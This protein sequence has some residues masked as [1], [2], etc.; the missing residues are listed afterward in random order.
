MNNL[1][2]AMVRRDLQKAIQLY[3]DLLKDHPE[4]IKTR[5]NLAMAYQ[6][7]GQPEAAHKQLT[8]LI[9]RPR[10]TRRPGCAG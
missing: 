10:V 7:V 8:D 1:A 5:Y 2:A 9:Q 3:V 6:R 4:Q